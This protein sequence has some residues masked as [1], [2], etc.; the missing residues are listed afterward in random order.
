MV[1][2]VE[3]MLNDDEKF[4]LAALL[5]HPDLSAQFD[6]DA[7]LALKDKKNLHP[8]LGVWRAKF[9]AFAEADAHHPNPDFDAH[10][11]RYTDLMT[12][13]MFAFLERSLPTMTE[14]KR[15]E[16]IGYLKSI[17]NDL[18]KNGRLSDGL[19]DFTRKMVAGILDEYR[20]H[21]STYAVSPFAQEAKRDS[22]SNTAALAAIRRTD[23]DSRLPAPKPAPKPAEEVAAK[24]SP[25]REPTVVPGRKAPTAPEATAPGRVTVTDPAGGARDQL[26]HTVAAG[27][28]GG[29]V[30]D[31]GGPSRQPTGGGVVVV[32]PGSGAAHSTLSPSTP[33]SGS[34][35][36]A[37]GPVPSPSVG[38]RADSLL[39]MQTKQV[40]PRAARKLKMA[41]ALLGG[42]LGA[43]IGFFVGGP[44]GAIAGAAIGVGLG[45]V[46]AG[47][48][49]KR[50]LK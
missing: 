14:N 42:L 44:V 8:F 41:A 6:K 2:Q 27:A 12:P 39:G 19:F 18:Q 29:Q 45:H 40:T 49:A 11:S 35:L 33:A 37:S 48:L 5:T 34:S 7:A 38:S 4:I 17:D 25:T 46:A 50:L 30:M 24:P 43:L 10:Y 15:N 47:M 13:E 1:S 22:V 28:N 36:T 23:E 3:K 9:D 21:L 31:G 20:K 32:P 16:V 26:D